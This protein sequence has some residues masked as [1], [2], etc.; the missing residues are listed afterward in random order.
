V[1]GADAGR[2]A[3]AV[4][5]VPGAYARFVDALADADR[6]TALAVAA[7]LVDAGVDP[8]RVLLDVVC[9]AQREVGERWAGNEWSVARE[10]AATA[11]SEAVVAAVATR[12]D[13]TP[14]RGHVVVACVEEEWHALPAR[15]VA[16]TLALAGWRTT[17]LG[18]STP[19]THLAQYLQDLG[20]D[21]VALSCSIATRLPR[22]RQMIEA[23]RDAGSAVVVGGAGFGAD[24]RIA[25]RLGADGWAPT[26]LAAVEVLEGLRPGD[27]PAAP[28]EHPGLDEQADLQVRRAALVDAAHGALERRFP[29][30]AGY[31]PEQLARTREDLGHILD[32]LGA[33]L[34][35]EEP[36][37][38]LDF[39]RWLQSV[40]VSR[41]VPER[42]LGL[43]YAAVADVVGDLPRARALLAEARAELPGG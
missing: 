24:D 7:E 20:P 8:A 3:T 33:A 17:Y 16:E 37:I 32:F 21:A 13:V 43:G 34:Y 6:R 35:V 10:H 36:R 31:T 28:P 14:T 27:E 1:T 19:P 11:I 22:A 29:P 12:V 18:A 2:G 39:T 41:G 42:A 23:A 9:P 26:A 15:V 38:F 4:A 30:L 5:D 40:L 25:R